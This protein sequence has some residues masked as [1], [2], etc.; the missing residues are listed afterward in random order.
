MGCDGEEI[1]I[2]EPPEERE[3]KKEKTLV[4]MERQPSGVVAA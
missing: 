2:Q 4:E 3:R 1:E